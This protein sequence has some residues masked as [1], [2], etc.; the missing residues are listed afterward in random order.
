M[1]KI[2]KD[3]AHL[4]KMLAR[5]TK[6]SMSDPQNSCEKK[7]GMVHICNLSSGEAETGRALVLSGQPAQPNQASEKLCLKHSISNKNYMVPVE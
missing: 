4:A 1:G 7:P 5:Q 2:T 3:I 6:E